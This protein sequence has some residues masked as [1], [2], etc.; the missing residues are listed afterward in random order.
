MQN[1]AAQIVNDIGYLAHVTTP[2]SRVVL[3]ASVFS[4]A[5]QGASYHL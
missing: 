3:V 2:S 4:G 5:I 1:A